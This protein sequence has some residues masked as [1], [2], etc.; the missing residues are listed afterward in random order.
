MVHLF[1][2]A[3][4]FDIEGLISSPFGPGRKKH[5]LEVIIVTKKTM[6]T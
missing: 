1:V 2:Y 5:I 6:R 3:D 4:V